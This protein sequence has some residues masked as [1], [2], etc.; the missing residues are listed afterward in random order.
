MKLLLI[1][2]LAFSLGNR[3]NEKELLS[4]MD[5]LIEQLKEVKKGSKVRTIFS[6]TLTVTFVIFVAWELV[7]GDKSIAECRIARKKSKALSEC[8]EKVNKGDG[9]IE[10]C[11]DLECII[12]GGENIAECLREKE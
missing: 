3:K 5:Q 7:C 12:R 2:A 1:L 9:D 8:L 4:Q 11:Y 10:K 6:S